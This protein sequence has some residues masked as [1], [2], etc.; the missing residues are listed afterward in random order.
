[1]WMIFYA[2]YISSLNK[3]ELTILQ[4]MLKASNAFNPYFY[5]GQLL[6]KLRLAK[7][8]IYFGRRF[9]YLAQK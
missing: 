2:D 6:R 9:G 4:G 1:M 3:G 8:K 5:F 7:L